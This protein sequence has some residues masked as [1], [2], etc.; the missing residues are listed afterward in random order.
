MRHSVALFVIL[1]GARM[2]AA[3]A[4]Y[5]RRDYP[6]EVTRVEVDQKTIRIEGRIGGEAKDLFLAEVPAHLNVFEA[7]EFPL[8]EPIRATGERFAL[9]VERKDRLLSRWAVVRKSARGYELVSHA[10]WADAVKSKWDTPE[11]KPRSKKGLGGFH[12]GRL[13]SDLDDLGIV[14]VTVNVSLNGIMRVSPGEG[15]TAFEHGGRTWYAD[16][17][18][19]ASLDRTI[20]AAAKRKLLVSAIIL[21]NPISRSPDK[22]WARLACHP[23][24]HPSGTYV[25]PNVTSRE[26]VQAYA[27]ALEFLARRYSGPDAPGRIHHWIMHNEVDAGWVWTNAG[28]KTAVQYM[29]LYHKSMRLAHLIARQYDPYAKAFIS[30]THHWAKAGEP[31]FYAGREM[32]D[33]LLDH[34]R[35][36]GDFDWAIAFHP[37][38]QDLFNPRVW[39]DG[40]ATH[41]FDTRKITFKNVEVLDAWVRQPRAMFLQKHRRTVHLSEQG[42]NSRD[43]SAKALSEQAAGM[44]Y[45]WNKIK[46]LDSIEVFHYHNWMDHRDE[47]GLRIGLRKFPDDREDPMGK[48]PIWNV[49][50]A[51]GTA[52]EDSATEFAKQVIGIGDWPEIRVTSP[53]RR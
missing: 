28:E 47:G 3:Q 20:G 53:P 2:C 32:L 16:D 43:Y 24:A 6:C 14:A 12:A 11:L 46:N 22:D 18:A 15:R 30:L 1:A 44:A 41:S 25:M 27:A 19:V 31:K 7:T 34:S 4:D 5:L 48:K 33:L 51:L 17:G 10:R 42:L 36:E 29:D 23:D 49:Y 9:T 39:A 26:G 38:P 40:Q 52:D 8:V 37:Y 35:A 45:A 13:D 50:K 21:I